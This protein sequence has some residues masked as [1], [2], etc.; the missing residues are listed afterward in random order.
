MTAHAGSVLLGPDEGLMIAFDGEH[1]RVAVMGALDATTRPL[2]GD[3]APAPLS[4]REYRWSRLVLADGRVLSG[5][6][7]A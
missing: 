4:F 5:W 1:Y 6:V 3:I 2:D 7:V